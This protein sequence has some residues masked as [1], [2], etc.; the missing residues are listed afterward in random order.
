[1]PLAMA[2][3]VGHHEAD[4]RTGHDHE[5]LRPVLSAC[6]HEVVPDQVA[7]AGKEHDH[8]RKGAHGRRVLRHD[9]R[10]AVVAEEQGEAARS[11]AHG[12][13][14]E[15]V[16]GLVELGRL[17]R[18]PD[19][20]LALHLRGVHVRG[21]LRDLVAAA[22]QPPGVR[23]RLVVRALA[24]GLRLLAAGPRRL[25][26]LRAHGEGNAQHL[27][28]RQLLERGAVRA[29]RLQRTP[30][31]HGQANQLRQDP[32]LVRLRGDERVHAEPQRKEQVQKSADDGQRV[33]GDE[34]RRRPGRHAGLA[35]G[36]HAEA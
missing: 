35:Q 14:A 3:L 20:P 36:H 30:R 34:P 25:L 13:A 33:G 17:A 24:R 22:L 8:A 10:H 7:G 23:G 26:L 32:H 29:R 19:V 2:G 12:D 31:W 1:M 6:E 15:R 18:E 16:V 4:R 9:V 5:E 28:L 27:A 21:E 11:R